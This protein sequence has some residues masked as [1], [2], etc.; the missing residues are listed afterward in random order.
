MSAKTDN[1]T[2]ERIFAILLCAAGAAALAA[3][4]LLQLSSDGVNGGTFPLLVS[5]AFLFLLNGCNLFRKCSDLLRKL[6]NI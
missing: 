6:L 2:A 5:A 3:S 4:V 1:R